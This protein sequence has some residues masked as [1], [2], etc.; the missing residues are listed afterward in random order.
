MPINKLVP[1]LKDLGLPLG[2]RMCSLIPYWSWYRH[3]TQARMLARTHSTHSTHA[4][5]HSRANAPILTS[6]HHARIR[7]ARTHAH[8]CTHVRTLTLHV[9]KSLSRDFL[10]SLDCLDCSYSH[11]RTYMKKIILFIYAQILTFSNTKTSQTRACFGSKLFRRCGWWAFRS[12][13]KRGNL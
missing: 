5:M 8:A 1:F 13:W 11:T 12:I 4:R 7:H 3:N 9:R 10:R 6:T 2:L